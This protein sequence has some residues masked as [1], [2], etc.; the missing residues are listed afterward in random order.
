MK[1]SMIFSSKEKERPYNRMP[2]TIEIDGRLENVWTRYQLG[3]ETIIG[4]CPECGKKYQEIEIQKPENI[5]AETSDPEIRGV[6]LEKLQYLVRTVEERMSVCRDCFDD[7]FLAK[8][9][10]LYIATLEQLQK[11]MGIK[12]DPKEQREKIIDK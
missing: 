2:I 3:R 9:A 8:R 10:K 6:V 4:D 5:E 7:D 12:V 11:E 1:E